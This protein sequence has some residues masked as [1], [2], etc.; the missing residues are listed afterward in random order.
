MEAPRAEPS[1]LNLASFEYLD[2]LGCS[3]IVDDTV[4]AGVRVLN[5][6]GGARISRRRRESLVPEVSG[7]GVVARGFGLMT[8][9]S[10]G[11]GGGVASSKSSFNT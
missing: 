2:S 1:L 5:V 10:E 11:C 7:C 4:V 3:A 6:G 8:G 9:A